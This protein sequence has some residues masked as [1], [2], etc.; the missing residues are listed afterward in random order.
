M[1]FWDDKTLYLIKEYVNDTPNGAEII[2]K[3]LKQNP[4]LVEYVST[5]VDSCIGMHQVYLVTFKNIKNKFKVGYTKHKNLF[6][7]FGESRYK[8]DKLIVDSI[9]LQQELPALGAVKFEEFIQS[10]LENDKLDEK[11]GI[12]GKGEFYDMSKLDSVLELW[13]TNVHKF[14][15]MWGIKSPN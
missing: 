2:N 14:K 7:R 11:I 13:T 1:E 8:G 3:L 10:K 4:K 9:I 15:D 12:P 5:T 6:K